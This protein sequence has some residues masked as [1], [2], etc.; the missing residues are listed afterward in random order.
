[1]GMEPQSE[2]VSPYYAHANYS[3]NPAA[4]ATGIVYCYMPSV[5]HGEAVQGHHN[6][7]Q[8]VDFETQAVQLRLEA[9]QLEQAAETARI[10]ARASMQDV[11]KDPTQPEIAVQAPCHR[12]NEAPVSALQSQ[13]ASP[14]Y[15]NVNYSGIPVAPAT[16]IVSC[17]MPIVT[18]GD[19]VQGL[20]SAQPA[21]D[22]ESQAVQLRLEAS[23]LE[24][25]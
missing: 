22:Y 1:M 21:V 5:T 18:H 8:A 12:N 9:S 17:Y 11:S 23:Q 3:G 2:T 4:P 20:P 10:H 24:E 14:C 25:A 13:T 6:A 16:G 19:A 7:Q 15:A